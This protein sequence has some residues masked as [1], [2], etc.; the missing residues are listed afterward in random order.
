MF[1][2]PDKLMFFRGENQ[3]AEPVENLQ[4]NVVFNPQIRIIK[5]I[6]DSVA[7]WRNNVNQI[8]DQKFL[9]Y[10]LAFFCIPNIYFVQSTRNICKYIRILKSD[11]V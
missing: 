4:A 7:I 1:S 6:V 5:H 3:S 2:V 9:F 10:G 8:N 11:I